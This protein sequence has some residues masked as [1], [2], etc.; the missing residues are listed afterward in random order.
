MK[1]LFIFLSPLLFFSLN[2]QTPIVVEL[3]PSGSTIVT[4]NLSQGHTM[5]DLSW[6]WN[7]SNAC[8]PATQ[9]K[10]FTGHHVLYATILPKYSEMEV[11]VTPTN[12]KNNFSIYAYEVGVNNESVVPNLPRCIRCEVDH[13]W[14]RAHVGKTQDHS[15][16][17]KHL[18]ALNNAYKVI[19]GVVGADGLTAGDY[20]LE[21]SVKTR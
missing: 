14:D 3:D 12:P 9:Q 5:N 20:S 1:A 17:A 4:G 15:R 21:F 7:S 19:V 18:V 13:K 8:F 2:T 16:T 11:T 10:K 6:A